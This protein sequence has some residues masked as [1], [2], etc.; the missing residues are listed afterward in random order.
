MTCSYCKGKNHNKKGCAK[1]KNDVVTQ[2]QLILLLLYV[3]FI[4]FL[5]MSIIVQIFKTWLQK[6]CSSIAQSSCASTQDLTATNETTTAGVETNKTF[7]Y[8]TS[9][10]A[11]GGCFLV[12]FGVCIICQIC[13][14]LQPSKR[15]N[16]STSQAKSGYGVFISERTGWTC[17]QVLLLHLYLQVQQNL[18]LES[19]YTFKSS[20]IWIQSISC[21]VLLNN[22]ILISILDSF[23]R[24]TY[25][26]DDVLILFCY[27]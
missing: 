15:R 1:R 2:V 11:L 16:Q 20:K 23:F 21:R 7:H 5:R 19:T 14:L 18:D 9:I 13:V 26:A 4:L 25:L 12:G 22:C 27:I 3:Y 6:N 24:N 8:S 10:I 17:Q